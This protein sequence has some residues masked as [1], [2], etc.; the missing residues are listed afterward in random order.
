MSHPGRLGEGK[1]EQGPAPQYFQAS[2]AAPRFRF[3]S[4]PFSVPVLS[5]VGAAAAGRQLGANRSY[6]AELFLGY[7]P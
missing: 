4:F 2:V 7:L 1:G 3:L 5:P 6:L